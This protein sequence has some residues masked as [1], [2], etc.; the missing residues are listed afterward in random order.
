VSY[1]ESETA[2][3]RR[4]VMPPGHWRE[5]LTARFAAVHEVGELSG[6]TG[7]LQTVL[8]AQTYPDVVVPAQPPR[9]LQRVL[10]PVLAAIGRAAGLKSPHPY[11]HDQL[12]E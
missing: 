11:P 5:A 9:T 10:F 12:D 6:V 2:R 1:T 3:F 4:E 8:L 7:L